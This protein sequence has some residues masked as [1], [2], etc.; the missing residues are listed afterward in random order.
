MR[1]DIG[2]PD[3]ILPGESGVFECVS[4][5]S[6]PPTE[7]QWKVTDNFGEDLTN[8]LQVID[9]NKNNKRLLLHILHLKVTEESTS[10]N[11]KGWQTFSSAELHGVEG[12][13][14]MHV[15]CVGSNSDNQKDIVGRK[16]VTLKCM[17][18]Q[19]TISKES[20]YL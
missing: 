5:P 16:Q 18:C 10:W 3:H 1:I 11:G 7:L 8:V 6:N 15:E 4:S 20:N 19:P 9:A 13:T 14:V 2:G 17:L 12:R